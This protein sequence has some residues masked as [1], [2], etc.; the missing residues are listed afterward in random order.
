[1]DSPY[2]MAMQLTRFSHYLQIPDMLKNI[3]LE[4]VLREGLSFFETAD[5]AEIVMLPK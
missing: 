5:R 3:S 2:D 4:D 1:M